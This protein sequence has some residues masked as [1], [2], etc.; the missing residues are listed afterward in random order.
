MRQTAAV[1]AVLTVVMCGGSGNGFARTAWQSEHP[2]RAEV[3]SRLANQN[4]RVRQEQR[5]GV[6][7]AQQ[8][9]QLHAQDYRI[10]EEERRMASQNGGHI[11][12]PEQI[13][14]N[15]RESAVSRE[16]GR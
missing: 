14:L 6:I 9:R 15:G 4:A 2:R 3:N 10:C 5:A 12:V 8:A 16:I 13:Y 1:M 7:N 11:T